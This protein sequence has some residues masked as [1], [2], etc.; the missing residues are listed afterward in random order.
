MRISVIRD[1][2]QASPFIPFSMRLVHGNSHLVRHPETISVTREAVY[3]HPMDSAALQ[4][5]D[6]VH[7]QVIEISGT[8]NMALPPNFKPRRDSDLDDQNEA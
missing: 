7:I 8:D 2:V 1:L 4:I 5:I 3:L 6:P